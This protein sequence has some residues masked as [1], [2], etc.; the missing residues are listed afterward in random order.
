MF[1]EQ[2]NINNFAFKTTSLP[3]KQKNT[4]KSRPDFFNNLK[5]IQH[6]WNKL[7]RTAMP[8]SKD[9][10]QNQLPP[11]FYYSISFA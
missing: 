11:L 4:L 1:H 5:S 9:N 8:I 3:E 10:H 7:I 6:H 2:L